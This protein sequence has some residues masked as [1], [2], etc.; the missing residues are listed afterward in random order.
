[1]RD[2]QSFL[3][4]QEVPV[5]EG[6]PRRADHEL[7]FEFQKSLRLSQV[8]GDLSGN[9]LF[10]QMLQ[11]PPARCID[12]MEV[13]QARI[14]YTSAQRIDYGTEEGVGHYQGLFPLR[15]LIMRFLDRPLKL[16]APDMERMLTQAIHALTT[17]DYHFPTDKLV[18]HLDQFKGQPEVIARWHPH[19]REIR[20]LLSPSF[21]SNAGGRYQYG[22]NKAMA[23]LAELLGGQVEGFVERGDAWA[24]RAV[25]DLEA[26]DEPTRAAWRALFEH[27]RQSSDPKPKEKWLKAAAPLLQA[28]GKA[29]FLERAREWFALYGKGDG[30][31]FADREEHNDAF[32]KGLVWTASLIE[33]ASI[34]PALGAALRGAFKARGRAG[35]RSQKVG[36]AC[37]W[38][39]GLRDESEAAAHLV[40]AKARVKNGAVLK[41]LDKTIQTVATRAGMSAE[42]L[43][44]IAVPDFGIEDGK[45]ARELGPASVE[46]E[47][48]SG[49]AVWNWQNEGKVV[50]AV[51]ASVKRDFAPELKELKA[52]AAEV[53]KVFAAQKERLDS[54]LRDEKSWEF[55]AWK[56]RYLDH[57]L[58]QVLAARLVWNFEF[59]A[60]PSPP[61]HAMAASWTH[62]A[63]RLK[64]RQ[65]RASRCSTR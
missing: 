13:A 25:A 64:S 51:P 50:K 55:A 35:V 56:T 39:L 43:E 24:D 18:A 40:G 27:A 33:D 54:M 14:D 5:E 49:K 22:G 17:A 38:A 48:A 42:D 44:E 31:W 26:M 4:P 30:W 1:M 63:R 19:L 52:A 61:C 59:V 20:Q 6:D 8:H 62:A 7:L 10:E 45:L 32:F 47:V 57:A 21:I 41:T 9:Y 23:G 2:Q 3:R 16:D 28:V 29:A 60:A 37:I 58:M 53:E 11:L 15:T 36:N 65:T 12:L 34:I 46:I